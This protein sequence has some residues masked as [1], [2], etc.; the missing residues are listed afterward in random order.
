MSIF[1]SFAL[2]AVSFLVVLTVIVFVHE[3][4]HY[5][6][7]RLNGVRVETFSIGFG[8][9][10]AG[11]YDRRGTRWKIGYVPFGG[12]VKFFGD[13]GMASAADPAALA[14]LDPEA[15]ASSFHHKSLWRRASIVFAGPAVNFIFGALVFAAIFATAGQPYTPPV[16]GSVLANS[17]AAAAGLEPGDRVVSIAG[18]AINRFE[19]IRAIVMIE[20]GT[21]LDFVVRRDGELRH[22]AVTPKRVTE[23]DGFGGEARVGQVGITAEAG[24]EFVRRVPLQ[25]LWDGVNQTVSVTRDS[26]I[27][28]GRMLVGRESGSELSGPLR[29]AKMA[30]EVAEVSRIG[31]LSLMATL[32]I[33]IGL[34]NL[35]P[36]PMLDGGHLLFYALEA[37]RGR[38]LGERAQE[39]G[40]R[41]GLIVVMGLF[42]FATWNDL[43]N[44]RVVSYLSRLF[45]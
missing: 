15:Q 44:L 33:S 26:L 13:A 12:Y 27:Y 16:V 34:V 7:A 5:I 38:P 4:G 28:V 35:F 20:A 6:V 17:A 19:D 41:L 22:F 37:L 32:S 25:A 1:A 40:F 11:W 36:I 45:S 9:E 30:G 18:H 31:L 14:A 21:R 42:F 2:Y 39:V 43:V 10:I 24:M 3:W 8:G 23:P 29:I